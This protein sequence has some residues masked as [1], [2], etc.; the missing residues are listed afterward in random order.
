VKTLRFEPMRR[1]DCLGEEVKS[2]KESN[3]NNFEM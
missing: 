2:K 3:E 1:N